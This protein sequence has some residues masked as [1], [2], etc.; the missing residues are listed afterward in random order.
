M[1][2]DMFEKT[3]EARCQVQT[4]RHPM[5]ASWIE[6]ANNA[7][8]LIER[9][10]ALLRAHNWVSFVELDRLDG[11]RGGRAL[12]LGGE[13]S[14]L[15][16]WQSISEQAIGDLGTL[17]AGGEAHFAPASPVVYLADGRM[18]TLPIAKTRH[19]YRRPHWVPVVL[20]RGTARS[21]PEP[22]AR[23]PARQPKRPVGGPRKR[24]LIPGRLRAAG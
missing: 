4:A 3:A 21:V 11:F 24:V 17:I 12:L 6:A 5:V 20:A 15:V 18:P 10:R 9:I 13:D 23:K 2:G 22:T 16:L 7:P 1:T 14:N 19:H 8:T